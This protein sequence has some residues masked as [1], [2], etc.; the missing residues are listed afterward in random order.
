MNKL[1]KSIVT[2]SQQTG[3]N[4]NFFEKAIDYYRH[5][6]AETLSKNIGTYDTSVSLATKENQIYDCMCQEISRISGQDMNVFDTTVLSTNPMVVWAMSNIMNHVID[7]VLPDTIIKSTGDYMQLDHIDWGGSASYDIEPNFLFTVSQGSNGQRVSFIQKQFRTT[8]TLMPVNHV[9]TVQASLYK[10]L[11]RQESLGSFIRKAVI[12]METAMT[13][14][15]YNAFRAG[16][17]AATVPTALSITGYTQKT[18]LQLL[19]TVE[20]YNHGAKPMILGTALALENI[21]PNG[22]DGYRINTDSD[23]MSIQLIRNFFGYDI[24]VLPQVA[25]GTPDYKLALNNTEL[26]I[27]S[28]NMDKLI[29]GVV[30]GSTLTNSNDYYDN[31]NLTSNYTMNKRWD[32]QWI[33]NA[34]AGIVHL[35]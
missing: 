9:I 27:V 30:E 35:Q 24:T 33:S 5:Y 26:Y 13:V 34:T 6:S 20:A 28:S 10:V 29:K 22:A 32:M 16:L 23:N 19:M 31:A 14:D 21:L 17:N 8:R 2:F 25:T 11:C 18:L 4:T 12:S 15:A 1:P 3:T 7:A